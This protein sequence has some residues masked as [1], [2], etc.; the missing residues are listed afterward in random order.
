M[1]THC[2]NLSQA[3]A[4]CFRNAEATLRQI[5]QEK[6]HA[7]NEEM[8]THLFWCELR[9]AA[10][11]MNR[12]DVWSHALCEDI[13]SAFHHRV[14]SFDFQHDYA[15]LCCEVQLHN[16]QREGK[17]GGDFGLFVS[18]PRV[19]SNYHNSCEIEMMNRAL[20]VQAKLEAD[21]KFNE[22]TPNQRKLFPERRDFMAL[23]LYAYDDETKQE[24][25]PFNWVACAGHELVG[26]TQ[27]LRNRSFESV[28]SSEGVISRL[29]VG[30]I[31]TADHLIIQQHIKSTERPQFRFVLRWP[32]DRR[33]EMK[34]SLRSYNRQ[35]MHEQIRVSVER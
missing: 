15:G 6:Y 30:R 16:K 10:H 35:T 1:N 11:Q 31:G 21:G 14:G 7:L 29:Y 5:I 27:D 12:N 8:I 9:S 19:V 2:S 25:R 33:P 4:R 24:L 17:T 18:V 32:D 22:L 23:A 13:A 34:V 3:S 20:L 26:I 28:M